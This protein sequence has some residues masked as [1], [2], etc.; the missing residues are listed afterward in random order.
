M[1]LLT[2]VDIGYGLVPVKNQDGSGQVV[3]P[4]DV[5]QDN[6]FQDER[7]ESSGHSFYRPVSSEL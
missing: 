4:D 6:Q 2:P 5:L 1:C 3:L 7:L